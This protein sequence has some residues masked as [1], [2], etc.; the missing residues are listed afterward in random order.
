MQDA[1]VT[2]NK[3]LASDLAITQSKCQ[4]QE[5]V[6]ALKDAQLEAMKNK[7]S[8]FKPHNVRRRLQRKDSRIAEQK[9]NIRML[10]KEV[11]ES[12]TAAIKSKAQYYQK[13]CMD[14]Q[15]KLNDDK[16]TCEHCSELEEQNA[17]LKQQN[18]GPERG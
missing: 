8:E 14:S 11:K 18:N 2:V 15:E 7:L 12:H 5:S 3:Q 6:L 17:K 9:E 1:L 16:N 4:E 10:E 13:K